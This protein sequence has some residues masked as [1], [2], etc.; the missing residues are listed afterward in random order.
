MEDQNK[1]KIQLIEELNQLRDLLYE[2]VEQPDRNSNLN[3]HS[4]EVLRLRAIIDNSP[5]AIVLLE[6][7]GTIIDFNSRVQNWLDYHPKEIIGKNFN[8]LPFLP[9]GSKTKIIKNLTLRISGQSVPPYEVTFTD[10][11]G[12]IKTGLISVSTIKNEKNK[13][14]QILVIISDISEQKKVEKTLLKQQAQLKTIFSA[15]ADLIILL[16]DNLVYQ[17]VNPAYCQ[18]TNKKEKDVIGKTHFDFFPEEEAK[19]YEQ[20]DLVV[21]KS[22]QQQI[23]ER[24]AYGI[25]GEDKW[26]QV[27]KAPIHS[28]S[29]EITGVLTSIRDI[30]KR[31]LTEIAIQESQE[32]YRS[33]ADATFEAVFVSEKGICIDV[34][35]TASDMFGYK[36]NELIGCF[37]TKFIAPKHRKTV[38]NNML[39]GYEKPYESEAL[40]KD[41]STFFC[42]IRGKMIKH[43]G[44]DLR[45]TVIRDIDEQVKAKNKL[46]ESEMKFKT[47]YS[48]S[49]DAIMMLSPE[50]GFFAGNE[51]SIKLFGCK[52]EKEFIDQEPASLSPLNQP[53]NSLSSEKAKKMMALALKK[54]SHFF[55]WKHKRMDGSEFYATV[56][57]TKMQFL[58]NK[59]LQA[60]VRDTTH[61][62]QAEEE[63]K[64][65]RNHLEELVRQRTK[66]LEEINI[67]LNIAKNKAEKSDNLKSAFLSNMSHEIRTP[68]NAIIGFSELLKDT[69]TN[70]ETKRE[71]IDIITNKGNLLM[72]IINDIIDISKIEANEME[73]SNQS[74]NISQIIDELL[75][76]F[77]KTKRGSDKPNVLL[78]ISKLISSDDLIV[79]C[80]PFRLKQILTNLID[81]ALK[82]THKGSVEVNYSVIDVA[83]KKE[84]MF[85]VKDTGIGIAEDKLDIIFNR[86]RQINESHTREFGGTGL[87]L[88]ISKR[89]VELLGGNIGVRSTPGM[90]STF[91]F[92]IPF[93]T[94]EKVSRYNE[95]IKSGSSNNYNW[96]NKTILIVEDDEI[97]YHLL[98]RYLRNTKA[99]I[100]HVTNGKESVEICYNNSNI[101]LVLMDIQLPGLNGYEATKLIKKKRKNLPVIAQTAYAL[102]GEKAK[103]IKAGCS[104]YISKPIDSKI[105]LPILHEYL[106]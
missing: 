86:F 35:Q 93:I 51:A 102:A 58:S 91:F 46:V 97:S 24:K 28:E 70:D 42:E 60:T 74:I 2:K 17:A 55:E 9:L 48:S 26:V 89:L 69:N 40:R 1:T 103:C 57:L 36:C 41:G 84:I 15:T 62:K 98:S 13:T 87:G 30:T 96:E 22:G 63:L 61:Q 49:Q 72:N 6:K 100:L 32:R 82:F 77:Q 21:L 10:R 59:V 27:V 38:E 44:K 65:H 64:N 78:K 23:E 83:G 85:E 105:L 33:L 31:K 73:I 79:L 92:T 43:K 56:L 16:D 8:D 99:K 104:D 94:G 25:N 54:G 19:I 45:I 53:D 52:D 71:Y 81:N 50:D 20:S 11:S 3:N 18:F 7:S 88:S 12:K 29:G 90:G 101:N 5:E 39:T 80:D 66:E 75:L 106:V 14:E 95:S 4:L 76:T 67:Q 68:M 47:L 34:N 37:G